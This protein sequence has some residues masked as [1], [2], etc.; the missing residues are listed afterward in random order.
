MADEDKARPS[1]EPPK[2]FGRR[3]PKDAAPAPTE[4]AAPAVV[5]AEPEPAFEDAGSD[6][7]EDPT[8]PDVAT[9]TTLVAEPATRDTQVIETPPIDH[10]DDT[11]HTDQA[12]G[13]TAV[14]TKPA[15]KPK[16]PKPP[17]TPREGPLM[18]GRPASLLIGLVVGAVLVG[19]TLLGLQGCQVVRG[20]SS[21]G[22]GPGM[23]AL[24]VIFGLS[25]VVG[26]YLLKA[27]HVP[28][29]GATS[30]LAV[31]LTCVV[32]LL[33][34]DLLDTWPVVILVPPLTALTFLMSY[35]VTTTYVDNTG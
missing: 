3:K 17:R 1:L 32:A 22:T 29:P 24:L 10:F 19:L 34:V 11:G 21:C 9:E 28:D 30:F 27:C 5:P 14:T 6:P 25:V 26:R 23:V 20:T 18:P 4:T 2:L 33:F 31:G 12:V 35:W 7:V 15:K 13:A 16:A 8:P